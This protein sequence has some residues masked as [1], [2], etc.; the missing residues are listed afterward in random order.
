QAGKRENGIVYSSLGLLWREYGLRFCDDDP[1]LWDAIDA[2]LIMPIDA[3]DNGQKVIETTTFTEVEPFTVD[4][5][6]SVMNP[7]A[8]VDE[9][10]D[11]D[12][13]FNQAVAFATMV[14]YRVKSAE[15]N[16]LRS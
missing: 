16:K 12:E 9:S 4:D 5:I 1:L 6:I 10:E 3:N 15:Q 11:Y 8:W 13:Q 7:L 14:L 2:R